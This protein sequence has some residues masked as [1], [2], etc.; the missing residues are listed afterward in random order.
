[1]SANL[2][3]AVLVELLRNLAPTLERL[4]LHKIYLDTQDAVRKL[5]DQLAEMKNLKYVKFNF[6]GSAKLVGWRIKPEQELQCHRKAHAMW[7]AN[8]YVILQGHDG[9]SIATSAR[10]LCIFPEDELAARGIRDGYITRYLTHA[11]VKGVDAEWDSNADTDDEST[12]DSGSV[13]G[14]YVWGDSSEDETENDE[15]EDDHDVD[16][17]DE[18]HDSDDDMDEDELQ[19]F[20]EYA[21]SNPDQFVWSR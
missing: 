8:P 16:D 6:T 13:A 18:E 11:P 5:F 19:A 17:D 7:P 4:T 3:G 10:T 9:S 12:S 2:D 1:M 20:N 21:R 15:E 14:D